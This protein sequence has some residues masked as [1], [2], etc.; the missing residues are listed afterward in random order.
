M[1]RN[2]GSTSGFERLYQ[3]TKPNAIKLSSFTYHSFRNGSFSDAIPCRFVGWHLSFGGTFCFHL[4]GDGITS[5]NVCCL[6][7]KK[8]VDFYV[9]LIVHLSIILAIDQLNAQILIL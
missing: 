2:G 3:L 8:C 9:L 4:Q 7:P 5:D 6:H 1:L